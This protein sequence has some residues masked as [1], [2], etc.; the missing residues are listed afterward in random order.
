VQHHGVVRQRV[1]LADRRSPS[2]GVGLQNAGQKLTGHPL[3]QFPKGSDAVPAKAR[4][5]TLFNNAEQSTVRGLSF[6]SL[7]SEAS[8]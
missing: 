3:Q 1:G 6:Q 8:D 5:P 2:V 7:R 4:L